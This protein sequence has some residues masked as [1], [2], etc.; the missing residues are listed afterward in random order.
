M[1]KEE[2]HRIKDIKDIFNK[3]L[4]HFELDKKLG[5]L[6]IDSIYSLFPTDIELLLDY[7]NNL[8]TE[9]EKL[10]S[11]VKYWVDIYAELKK[12]LEKEIKIKGSETAYL[13]YGKV[14]NK[15][16]ELENGNE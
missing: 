13:Y 3:K 12:W 16:K 6:S 5:Q 15:I 9:N 14:L 1:N 8:E 10:K 11:K 4:E 7:I 2:V